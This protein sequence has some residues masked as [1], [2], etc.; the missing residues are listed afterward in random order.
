MNILFVS[1]NFPPEV[2]APANRIY[3]HALQWVKEG[4][5]I[6]II[7]APPNFPEGV[8]H[9]GYK[10]TFAGEN[11]DGISVMRIPMYIA[12]NKGTL[13]RTL[14]YL[15]F[16]LSSI[17]YSR[18][19]TAHPNVVVATSPQFFA[20]IG[21][22]VI[23]RLKRVPFVLEV[24][25]LWP[26]SIVAVGA[27]KRNAIIRLFERIERFLYRRADHI[28]VVTETFKRVI[29]RK[30]ISPSRISVLKNGVDVEVF[31]QP[32]DAEL[33]CELRTRYDLHGKF[34]VSYIGTIGMA[35]RA[36]ILLEAAQMCSDEDIV[37]LVMGAGSERES[38][39]ERQ[40]VLKL[41]N[42]RLVDKQPR[43]IARHVLGLSDVS[44]VHLRD[45]P[46]FRSVIPSKIFEAMALGKPI[47]IGVNGESRTLVED[48]GAGLPFRPESAAELAEVVRLLRRDPHLY[49]RLSEN[50]CAAVGQHFDRKTLAAKYISILESVLGTE[51]EP[52]EEHHAALYEVS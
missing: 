30:G 23:S 48:A 22:Y 33:L 40:R 14:S 9:K 5:G 1:A 13:R 32:L 37:F 17:W 6:E 52:V 46:L 34:V 50:G 27:M 11:V 35:H 20:A 19:S 29:E 42:F 41:R 28:V 4:I 44:V 8:L 47:V 38:L 21:G 51:Y 43:E 24:R 49:A 3:E 10:N 18:K 7:T 2:N 26:E 31:S 25:D 36:D 15:S 45:T 16:M 12:E 39:A